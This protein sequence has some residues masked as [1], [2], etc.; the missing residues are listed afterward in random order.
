VEGHLTFEMLISPGP[1]QI[2][3]RHQLAAE[4]QLIRRLVG[5]HT[6]TPFLGRRAQHRTVRRADPENNPSHEAP[7]SATLRIPLSAYQDLTSHCSAFQVWY[8]S[9]RREPTLTSRLLSRAGSASWNSGT[10]TSWSVM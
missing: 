7:T 8:E 5:L 2:V 1:R 10:T 3:E 4:E 6:L 9:P